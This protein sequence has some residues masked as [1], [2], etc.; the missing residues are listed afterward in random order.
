[1]TARPTQQCSRE[2][3][4]PINT[5]ASTG[6]LE[7]IQIDLWPKR[8]LSFGAGLVHGISRELN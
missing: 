4:M 6:N 3:L 5:L 2:V 7:R 1:M 8:S